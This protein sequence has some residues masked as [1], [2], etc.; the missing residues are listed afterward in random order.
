MKETS[1][2]ITFSLYMHK[3]SLLFI[4]KRIQLSG[5]QFLSLPFQC[6]FMYVVISRVYFF[7]IIYM[8]SFWWNSAMLTTL[9]SQQKSSLRGENTTKCFIPELNKMVHKM[10]NGVAPINSKQMID[11]Y[12]DSHSSKKSRFTS[13]TVHW[14]ALFEICSLRIRML[15]LWSGGNMAICWSVNCNTC[16]IKA[17]CKKQRLNIWYRNWFTSYQNLTFPYIVLFQCTT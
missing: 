14:A 11:I 5:G 4:K 1:K 17:A 12:N 2:R 16:M 3:G 6:C 10:R 15:A 8:C 13:V 7:L 9:A